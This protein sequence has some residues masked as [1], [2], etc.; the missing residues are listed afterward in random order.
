MRYR[1][2]GCFWKENEVWNVSK[3]QNSDNCKRSKLIILKV[4]ENDNTQ[5]QTYFLSASIEKEHV[6]GSSV[7]M[8]FW[9]VYFTQNAF[10]SS[11]Y[12]CE[13]N[14]WLNHF[15]KQGGLAYYV[16]YINA[17]VYMYNV[18]SRAEL[19]SH[20]HLFKFWFI[21]LHLFIAAIFA[22]LS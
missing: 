17:A 3:C 4:H 16:H 6:R 11:F 21:Y 22:I 8:K 9:Y 15:K 7:S 5:R 20:L 12:I 1:S 2:L 14:W 18:W 10:G 19:K 13:Y